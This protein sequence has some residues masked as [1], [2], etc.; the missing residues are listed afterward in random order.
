MTPK[1]FIH[2]YTSVR[3]VVKKGINDQ[4]THN[5]VVQSLVIKVV[6]IIN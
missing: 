6:E 3:C 2:Y 5:P 4:T 1:S